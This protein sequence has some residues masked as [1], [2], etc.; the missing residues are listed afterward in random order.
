MFHLVR[1]ANSH[2]SANKQPLKRKE[3]RSEDWGIPQTTEIKS[4][5]TKRV[6][7]SGKA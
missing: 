3:S 2:D 6:G 7:P 4:C 5:G 1:G